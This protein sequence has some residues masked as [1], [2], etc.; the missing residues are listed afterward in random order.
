[1]SNFGAGGSPFCSNLE[2]PAAFLWINQTPS[3]H[4]TD[5]KM[6]G[7]VQFFKATVIVTSTVS[8]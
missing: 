3:A 6:P 5:I 1:M 7:Q 2:T 8:V 4:L